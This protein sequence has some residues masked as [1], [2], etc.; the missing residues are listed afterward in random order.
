MHSIVYILDIHIYSNM[1]FKDR[2]RFKEYNKKYRKENREK[3][4]EYKKKYRKENR[5]KIKECNKKYRKEHREYYYKKACE[6]SRNYGFNIL[7][8]LPDN[9]KGKT[10]YHHI[11]DTDV[12]EMPENVHLKCLAGAYKERHRELMLPYVFKYYPYLQNVII[13]S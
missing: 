1:P 10:V 6:R 11:T 3:F 8:K 7:G 5:E 2:E 13:T 12:V 9:F 4:K